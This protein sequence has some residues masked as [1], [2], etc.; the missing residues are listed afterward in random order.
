MRGLFVVVFSLLS[1]GAVDA[2]CT[3]EMVQQLRQRGVD[4]QDIQ[5]VCASTS[6]RTSGTVC[7]TRVGSC[8]FRGAANIPCTCGGP[9]GRVSGT[10]K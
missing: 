8:P 4:D 3:P 7:V 6:E 1:G 5:N 2:A 9:F 10:S